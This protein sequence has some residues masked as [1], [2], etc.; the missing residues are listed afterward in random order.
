MKTNKT[1][2]NTMGKM[3]ATLN[4]MGS[5][6]FSYALIAD[7]HI[8][9]GEK[10][11]NSV[12]P[13]N[14]LHNGRLRHVIR[15]I[16]NRP[17]LKFVIHLGDIVHPVPAIPN[18]FSEAA[19]RFNEIIKELKYDIHVLPGNHDVGD[20]YSD[21][22][23]AICI[24]EG[25]LELYREKFGPDF[26]AFDQMGVHFIML[27]APLINSGLESEKMQRDWLEN[28]FESKKGERF[29]VNIHYP[30]FLTE[31]NEG[32]HYDNIDE[33]GRTWLLDLFQKYDVE[34]LFAGHVH[35]FWYQRFAGIDCYYLPS[36]A[37]I[38][39]DYSEM[40]RTPPEVDMEGGRNDQPKH[41][42]FLIHIYERGHICEVVR[43]YGE[44]AEPGTTAASLSPKI[45]PLHPIENWRA[46]V[47]FDMRQDWMDLIQVPPSGGTDEFNRKL[48]RNDYPLLALWEMGIR[49]IRIPKLDILEPRRRERLSAL[50]DHGHEFV[51]YSFGIPEI[52]ILNIL[53]KNKNIV[54]AL[55]I[56][57][58]WSDLKEL[59]RKIKSLREEI[60]I[61]IYLSKLRGKEEHEDGGVKFVHTINHGFVINEVEQISEVAAIEGVDGVVFRVGCEDPIWENVVAAGELCAHLDIS[62]SLIVRMSALSPADYRQDDL[63]TA[64]RISEAIA[65]AVFQA[66]THVI[67]D[68]FADFDRGY[69]RRNGVIDRLYNPRLGF[70]VVRHLYG[71]LNNKSNKFFSGKVIADNKTRTVFLQSENEN[72]MLVLPHQPN[73]NYNFINGVEKNGSSRTCSYIDLRT[74][75]IKVNPPI[76]IDGP[77][78]LIN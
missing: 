31:R 75:E 11:T 69:F 2:N 24:S 43:T 25:Y 36:T 40:A 13:V 14:A 16:N 17:N 22:T 74:G 10:E 51:L 73:T 18:L 58:A 72:I 32:S 15:D 8:N 34:V 45:S 37:M 62:S 63:W 41:G 7:T 61:P 57:F 66:N 20:K 27:N 39:Q 68:T 38:R 44:L 55:E 48:A 30:I 64:N 1:K 49:R 65:A 77:F 28:Y 70:H 6:L 71:A 52:E 78:L 26:F 4:E 46:P 54:S 76:K 33:P 19:K 42:Y 59:T 12:Y 67:I 50:R 3:S 23:P 60:D 5:K 21:W 47:G 53:I 29:I 35:N 9:H 56:T